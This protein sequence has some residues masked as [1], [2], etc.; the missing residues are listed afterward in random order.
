MKPLRNR[1]LKARS[2]LGIPWEILERDYI[3]S[4]ILAGVCQVESLR[5]KL[6]FKGGTALK[7]CYF[8]DYRF[9]E[10]LDFSGLKDVPTGK[11]MERAIHEVCEVAVKL[12]D[13]YAP[14]EIECERYSEREP[15]PGGLEAFT[16]RAR[17]P[18]QHVP[19]TRIMVEVAV[20]EEVLKPVQEMP[21]IHGYDEPLEAIIQVYALEEII[22]EKLR[23]ILQ[24]RKRLEERGWGRSRARD[25]YDLWRI[26]NTFRDQ[27]YLDDF[28]LFLKEKCALRGVSFSGLEDFFPEIVLSNVEKTWKQW[29]GP[30]VPELPSFQ[31]VITDLKE[32]IATISDE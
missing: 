7:K 28:T 1:L 23:S 22:A 32:Q 30:L 3:L 31:V 19:L 4:W 11:T 6:V 16:I 14:V 18:W 10:D 8:G 2:R 27:L 29:L 13:T 17:L 5:N 15:H 25:Y 20:D 21:I 12:L 9:S 24:H 26:L